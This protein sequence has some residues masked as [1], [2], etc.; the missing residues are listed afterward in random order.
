MNIIPTAIPDI[1]IIEPRVHED[2]RGYFFESYQLERFQQAGLPIDFVQ[3]NEALSRGPVLR[4]LHYQRYFP[5]GKLVRVVA[6]VVWDVAVDIRQSSPTF[7]QWVG[8]ELSADNHRMLYI[9]PGFAHGYCSLTD[10][11][12]F[13]YKCTDVYHPDDEYGIR[14]NDPDLAITWPLAA[15]P[16][17]SAKDKELPVLKDQRKDLLFD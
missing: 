1:L 6:G 2:E 15:T 9:P 5:Q 7:G 17:I 3:D 8:E 10:V 12:I 14:W 16:R 4:G 13:Q 11:T